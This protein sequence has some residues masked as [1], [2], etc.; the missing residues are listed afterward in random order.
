MISTTNQPLN[1]P[2]NRL[3]GESQPNTLGGTGLPMTRKP[4][5][6]LFGLSLAVTGIAVVVLAFVLLMLA[7]GVTG[8]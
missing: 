6:R 8:A 3:S 2:P 1:A 7:V 5:R 4:L